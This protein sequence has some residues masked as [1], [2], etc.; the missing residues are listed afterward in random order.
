MN[1]LIAIPTEFEASMLAKKPAKGSYMCI[2]DC[3]P[4]SNSKCESKIFLCISGVGATSSKVI[5]AA[6]EKDNIK[7]LIVIGMAGNLTSENRF[8]K[9]YLVKS[10]TD[11]NNVISLKKTSSEQTTCIKHDGYV[12]LLTVNKPVFTKERKLSLSNYAE[13]VDMEG[14]QIAKFCAQNKIELTMIR[15]VSDDCMGDIGKFFMN[16]AGL[17]PIPSELLLAQKKIA[18]TVN[19]IVKQQ[20]GQTP[21]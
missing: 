15:A 10:V 12:T 13:L 2:K 11:K 8:G 20:C 5:K 19:A 1:Q 21:Q 6:V 9:I 14:Y 3:E 16:K 7:K 17:I 18:E 4:C